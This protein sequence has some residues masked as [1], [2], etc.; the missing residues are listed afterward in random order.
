MEGR[1][2]ELLRHPAAAKTLDLRKD[3]PDPVT[4]LS[5]GAKFSEDGVV[6]ALLRIEK[7]V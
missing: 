5:S 4:G 2:G 6:D 1:E 7:A 3:K